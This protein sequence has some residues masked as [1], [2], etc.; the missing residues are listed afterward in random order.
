MKVDPMRLAILIIVGVLVLVG[1]FFAVKAVVN[2]FAPNPSAVI[3]PTQQLPAANP[4]KVSNPAPQPTKPAN[5]AAEPTKGPAPV[6]TTEPVVAGKDCTGKTLRVLI[7]AYAGYYPVIYQAM[8]IDNPNYCIEIVPAWFGDLNTWSEAER[9]AMLKNGDIDVYFLTN[10]PLS[11]YGKDVA[12]PIAI[13]GQSTGADQIVA[14]KVDSTGKPINLFNDL[15]TSITYSE[16]GVSQFMV[17]NMLRTIGRNPAELNLQGSGDPVAAFNAGEFDA[18]GYFD[19]YIRSAIRSD[20]SQVL[21]STSWWRI[22]TDNMVASPKA[23]AEKPQAL[24]AFLADWY[25]STGAFTVDKMD[26]T[27]AVMMKWTY[28]GESGTS[29][30][31]LDEANPGASLA[32][33]VN[34]VAF[35]RYSQS[36]SAYELLPSGSNYFI[37]MVKNSRL[38][39]AWGNIN[40]TDNFDPAGWYNINFLQSIGTDQ[41]INVQGQFHNEYLGQLVTKAPA[42]DKN[43]LL[44]M[45]AIMELPYKQVKFVAGQTNLVSGEDAKIREMVQPMITLINNS[46]D[47]FIVVTGGSAWPTGDSLKGI[48]DFAVLRAQTLRD[49]LVSFGIPRDRIIVNPNPIVPQA[50][51]SNENDRVQFRIVVIDV[52]TASANR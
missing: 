43:T 27:A 32:D 31:G 9:A 26:A 21:V 50:E 39:W 46:P 2:I 5:P 8:T 34:K 23:V 1:A 4:T 11:L 22:V 10:G 7:D 12:I 25:K 51:Q 48:K 19:P 16:G 33:L 30:L 49:L 35:A 17:L 28:N 18:V 52:R 14:R 29:W 42:L 38:V 41:S 37:D 24:T 15:T 40:P 6:P 44:S 47:T 36:M 20:Y 3:Q 13:T 45:P